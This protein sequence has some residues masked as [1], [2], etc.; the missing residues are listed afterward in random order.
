ADQMEAGGLAAMIHELLNRDISK[1]DVRKVP[2]TEA[3]A[4]Q[5]TLSLDD[6]DKWWRAVLER[7]FVWESRY[8]LK[9]F[10]EWRPFVSTQLLLKSHLQWCDH[11]R[12]SRPKSA[13]QLGKRMTEMYRSTRPWRDEIIGEAESSNWYTNDP[14]IRQQRA[15]G[16]DVG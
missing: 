6:L 1:F 11:N 13:A 10:L 14:I 16:Y 4:E 3:L 5:K 2:Q 12:I 15:P 8:G 7:G 9:E